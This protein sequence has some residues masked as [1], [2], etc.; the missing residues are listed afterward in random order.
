MINLAKLIALTV[1][2]TPFAVVAEPLPK[3]VAALESLIG[4]WKGSGTMT[5]G[6]D[7]AKLDATWQ[8]KRT[9]AQWGVLCSFRVT[10]IPGLAV[11]EETDLLGYEANTNTYHWY[12][13]TNAGETHDHVAKA[14]ESTTIQ[15]VFTG[16]QDG[17]PFKEVIDMDIAKDSKSVAARGETFVGG[18]SVSLLELKLRK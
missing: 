2:A 8:C 10:G 15:F 1:L 16:V 4:S 5:M 14:T 12:S 3:P 17:K 11:F 7:K 9:A 13:V 18:A 6:K